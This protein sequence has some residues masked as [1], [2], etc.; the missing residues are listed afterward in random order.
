MRQNL[1]EL[2]AA[3]AITSITLLPA[4]NRAQTISGEYASHDFKTEYIG[5]DA[6]GMQTVRAWGKGRDR[7]AATEQAER[8]ALEAV[9]FDGLA[10][11]G[12]D[13]R[14]LVATVNARE[15]HEEYFRRFFSTDGPYTQFI[16]TDNRKSTRIKA[17]DS[18]QQMWGIVATIDV[19]ALKSRLINDNIITISNLKRN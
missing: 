8:N 4:C 7:H 14:P 16:T 1:T 19:S 12:C 18:A 2:L 15:K 6:M 3:L 5:S 9:I 13:P 10:E 17:K 11:K